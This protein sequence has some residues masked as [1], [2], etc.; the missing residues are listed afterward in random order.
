MSGNIIINLG[1][2]SL[3]YLLTYYTVLIGKEEKKSVERILAVGA[4]WRWNGSILGS[5][6]SFL[7]VGVG[8]K[9]PS[10]CSVSELLAAPLSLAVLE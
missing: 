2:S 10:R 7:Y 3:D 9:K 8:G 5:L 4:G 6:I 1:I